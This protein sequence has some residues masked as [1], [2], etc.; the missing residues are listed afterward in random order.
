MYQLEHMVYEQHSKNYNFILLWLFNQLFFVK[1]KI[2]LNFEK[3]GLGL[4][5][6][7][8]YMDFVFFL[9]CFNTI[10][11]LPLLIDMLMYDAN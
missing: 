4:F 5:E 11:H 1:G 10:F 6:K 7:A 3:R 8:R 2:K 9:V